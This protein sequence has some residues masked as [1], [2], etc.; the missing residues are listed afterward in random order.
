MCRREMSKGISWKDGEWQVC[1][2][3]VNIWPGRSENVAGEK[4]KK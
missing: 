1:A 3:A 2:V 4:K